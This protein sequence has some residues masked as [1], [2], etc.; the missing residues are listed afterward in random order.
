MDMT[1]ARLAKQDWIDAALDVLLTSG[2]DA[3]AV[4]PLARRLGATKGSFYW[5]FATRD[6]LLTE[7]LARW[8]VVA[9]D[10]VI[11]LLEAMDAS[12]AEKATR[13]FAHVM[14]ASEKRPGE[15]LLLAGA[16]HPAIAAAVERATKR[17]LAY[18]AQLLRQTGLSADVARR[19]ADLAYAAY[20]G[21]AQLA[22]AVPA[23]LPRTARGRRDLVAEMATTLLGHNAG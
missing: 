14:T 18:V 22:H 19:R 15:L 17:R 4:Q 3:V 11:A 16:D 7:T 20:L 9:T 21:H 12:A 8:E 5:H 13:L 10:D 2:P 6:E 23:V 1:D